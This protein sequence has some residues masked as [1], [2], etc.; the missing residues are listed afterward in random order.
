M[1]TIHSVEELWNQFSKD[2]LPKALGGSNNQVVL[3]DDNVAVTFFGGI[4]DLPV[5]RKLS[6][7]CIKG[8]YSYIYFAV[9]G[10]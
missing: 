6:P 1:E 5:H 8:H 10:S 4:F 7:M 3:F 9:A 2:N